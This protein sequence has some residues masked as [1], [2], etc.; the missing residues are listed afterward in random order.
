MKMNLNIKNIIISVIIVIACVLSMT[1]IA[2]KVSDPNAH[3]ETIEM[4]TEK[5]N[6]VLALAA[7]SSAAS[8]ALSL[9]PDDNGTPIANEIA[10]ITSYL[11]IIT[12]VLFMEK[13]MITISTLLAFKITFPIAGILF[14]VYLLKGNN[15]CKDL[16]IKV[17][18]FTLLTLAIIPTSVRLTEVIEDIHQINYEQVEDTSLDTSSE[19]TGLFAL[20]ENITNTVKDLPEKAKNLMGEFIDTIAV[21]LVTSCI[22][23]L[24]VFFAY[25]GVAKAVFKFDFTMSDMHREIKH[26]S[27]KARKK[28]ADMIKGK[29]DEHPSLENQYD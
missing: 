25:F 14:V 5:Q 2:D 6:Q 24:G 8:T 23:P 11:M 7:A 21:F 16:A 12:C 20:L 15:I 4:L 1:V 22:I 18:V 9:L 3:S 17:C 10:E 26:H 13:F 29:K 27:H 19:K 28:T